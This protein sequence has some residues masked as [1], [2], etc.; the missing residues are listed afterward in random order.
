MCS[1]GILGKYVVQLDTALDDGDPTTG[2]MRAGTG[3]G[4]TLTPVSTT[5]PLD[6]A[7]AYAVCLGF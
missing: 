7:V 5:N 3:S 2:S 4:T 6:E 1:G